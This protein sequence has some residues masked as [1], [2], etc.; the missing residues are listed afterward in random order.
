M[1]FYNDDYVYSNRI[2]YRC[3][4][5]KVKMFDN[6]NFEKKSLLMT[7]ENLVFNAESFILTSND[8]IE[9]IYI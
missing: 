1:P 6:T 7:R 4:R 9:E 3:D 2:R 5:I 8:S